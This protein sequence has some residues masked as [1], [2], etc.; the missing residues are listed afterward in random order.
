MKHK[1][2]ELT[3]AGQPPAA[4]NALA[5]DPELLGD[6]ILESREY[7]SSI[8]LQLLTLEQDP[9]NAEAIHSIFRGFHTI[10]GLAGFLELGMVQEVAHE[11]ES[12]LD[13]ARDGR[14]TITATVIDCVLAS[15]D[16]LAA[17]MSELEQLLESG[18]QPA[19]TAN[20]PLLETIRRLAAKQDAAP[21]PRADFEAGEEPGT[22][23][24]SDLI[25][26]AKHAS[27]GAGPSPREGHPAAKSEPKAEN[28][29]VESR[30]IKVDTTKLDFLVDMVGEMVIAQSL[31][32]HDPDLSAQSRPKLAR[33]LSQLARI[34]EEVQKTAMSMRMVPVGQL[35]QK[36]GR[37]VRDLSK[38]Q[39]K[40]VELELV[41]EDTELDRNIVEELSDPLMH[42]VRNGI[43]HGI[44]TPAERVAAGKNPAARLTLSAGHQAGHITIQVAE[45]GRGLD[46]ARIV[47]KAIKNGLIA[48][49]EGMSDHE[50]NNLI[51]SPGFST[52]AQV[53]DVSG[54]GVGMDV[55]K[56]H[57]QKLRGRIDIETKPGFGTTFLMKVPLTLAIIDGLVVGVGKERYIVP[58]YTVREMLRPSEDMIATV[59]GR[60][61]M[62]MV[63]GSLLPIVRLHSKF[64]VE[65]RSMNPWECLL[66]VSESNQK[67]FC[68]LVDE[69][70]GKQEVV[71]KSLGP[72]LQ[73]ISGVAGGAILGDG[74]VGLIL[75]LEGLYGAAAHD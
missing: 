33:N 23:L 58:I 40:Q 16:Y 32:Q 7:L 4:L 11:V 47:A 45:D 36:M 5:G 10:K 41:G 17:W 28:K 62:A 42:M 66:I 48:T 9:A 43:D 52:A 2:E 63:R 51:F 59:R 13:M 75:D 69:L 15:K 56:R 14:L 27:E 20:L 54:R 25:E 29:L 30:L 50:V 8:E 37:L 64:N 19:M 39:G 26:L 65:P 3:E 6:F 57:V 53:T 73:G 24:S 35:F 38:K 55:V 74:R 34:T 72:T 12:L 18:Q 46:R 68:L 67:R 71:I 60:S 70:V 1:H 61:E 21:E 22:G 49:G 31:V 44:E